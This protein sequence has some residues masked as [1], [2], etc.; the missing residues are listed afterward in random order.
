MILIRIRD[1]FDIQV[2]GFALPFNQSV[3]QS[4]RTWYLRFGRTNSRST[5]FLLLSSSRRRGEHGVLGKGI[6]SLFSICI[7]TS[8]FY[9]GS[10]IHSL[11]QLRLWSLRTLRSTFGYNLF[12]RVVSTRITTTTIRVIFSPFTS[13]TRSLSR[14]VNKRDGDK[15]DEWLVKSWTKG[16]N[17]NTITTGG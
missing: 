3:S 2:E 5:M 6:S 12:M 14:S 17:N 11:V 4:L 10:F 15:N 13:S 16:N 9:I 7:S 8:S 1:L